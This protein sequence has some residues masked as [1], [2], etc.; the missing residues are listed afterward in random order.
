MRRPAA[1]AAAL[2]VTLC[3]CAPQSSASAVVV[4][5]A[6]SLR[7]TF[8]AIAERFEHD[9]PG[10]RVQFDFASAADL[11]TQLIQGAGADVFASADTAQMARVVDAGLVADK[12]VTFASNTLAIVTAPGNPQHIETFADLARPGLA[13]V[14]SP[15]PMPCGVATEEVEKITGVHLNPVSEE[16]DVEDVLNKVA[17][18]QADAGLVNVTD[19]IAAGDKVDT[20]TF[21]EATEAITDYPIAVLRSPTRDE[22]AQSFVDLVT[23]GAGQAILHRAGFADTSPSGLSPR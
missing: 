2:L 11:A 15:A 19:A 21:P 8:T 3:G 22:L 7:P 16:P 9:H 14:V 4:Y 20:V 1:V 17:T 5:A 12:P 23:D 10:A 18:G 6:A 13:V